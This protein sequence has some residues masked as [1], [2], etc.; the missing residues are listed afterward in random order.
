M[1]DVLPQLQAVYQYPRDI[2]EANFRAF[3]ELLQCEV[4]F[5]IESSVGDVEV[6]L[7]EGHVEGVLS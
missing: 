5:I 7:R 2:I 1:R 4:V 6:Y 3:G